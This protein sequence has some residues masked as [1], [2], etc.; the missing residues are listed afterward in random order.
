MIKKVLSLSFNS[1]KIFGKNIFLFQKFPF[2]FKMNN[3]FSNK[4]IFS[5]SKKIKDSS[6][7]LNQ[8]NFEV[9][10]QEK[11]ISFELLNAKTLK[12][13]FNNLNIF[14]FLKLNNYN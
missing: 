14:F 1:K 3:L 5:I 4:Q 7:E 9:I 13:V 6:E 8:A 11:K 10:K 12:E 2:N